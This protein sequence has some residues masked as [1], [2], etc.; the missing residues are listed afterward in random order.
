MAAISLRGHIRVLFLYDVAEAI[1]LDVLRSMAEKKGV[2]LRS[3]LAH[4]VPHHLRFERPPSIE[5]AGLMALDTGESVE[6]TTK[7]YDD[8]V[9]SIEMELPFEGDWDSLV[10]QSNRWSN[11]TELENRANDLLAIALKRATP[12]LVR[13][14]KTWLREDYFIVHLPEITAQD[15]TTLTAA[16]LLASHAREVAQLVRG[17][18]VP[19]SDAERQEVLQSSISYSR[20]DLLVVGWTG[21]L[22]YGHSEVAEMTIQ[23]LEY[24]N[25]QLLEFR[26]YDSLLT[27]LLDGVYRSL[28]RKSGV[29]AAW[30]LSREAASLNTIRLDVMELTEKVDNAIKFL[31]D[32]FYARLYNLAAAKVGVPDYRALVDQKLRTAG[33]LYRFMVDQFNQTRSFVLELAVVIILIIEFFFLFRG[34]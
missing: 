1:G 2:E 33:E 8:G 16:D 11:A 9:V 6:V 21:A 27:Q 30:R 24:A 31:S 17:E 20:T 32:M 13:P 26:H 5:P 18:S 15:G 34:K 14:Y 3:S 10:S 7:Y 4:P 19:L 22:V 23:V 12:A 25:T 28:E 29:A